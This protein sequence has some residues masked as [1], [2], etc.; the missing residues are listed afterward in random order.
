MAAA[1]AGAAAAAAAAPVLVLRFRNGEERGADTDLAQ[2]LPFEYA[3]EAP[4]IRNERTFRLLDEYTV[5]HAQ[6]ARGGADAVA[7]IA[8][9]DRAFMARGVTDT[10][11]LYDLFVGATTLG[12]DGLSDLCAQMTADAVKRRPVEEVKALLGITDVGMTPE[13]ELK[14]QHDNDAILCLR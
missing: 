11:M 4:F 9:W 6:H 13:E 3:I 1:G 5:I 12:M 2:Q 14:L 7:D 10:V 8:A